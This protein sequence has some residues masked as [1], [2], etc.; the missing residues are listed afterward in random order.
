MI[1]C[2]EKN[3]PKN[4]K[5][6]SVDIYIVIVTWNTREVTCGCI[7]SIYDH[8][9]RLNYEVIVIDNASSDDSV[10]AIKKEYP[11]VVVI[12]NSEKQRFCFSK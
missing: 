6:K 3:L 11:Q 2:Q 12:E 7:R 10:E 1:S 8:P 4:L 5:D 9:G